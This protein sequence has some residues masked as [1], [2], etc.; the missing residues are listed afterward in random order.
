MTPIKTLLLTGANNHD[1]QRTAPFIQNLLNQSGKFEV[2]L[3]E[4]PSASLEANLDEYSLLFLDYNGPDWSPA[5][6]ANFLGAVRGGTGVVVLHAAN[7]SFESW[8][9]YAQL[10]GLVWRENTGHGEFHRFEVSIAE[11]NHPITRNLPNFSTED[12]LYHALMPV[13]GANL[14]VLAEAYSDPAQGGSGRNEPMLMAGHFGAGRVFHTALGHVW[15]D[16]YNG[17]YRGASLVAIEN[18]GFQTTLLRGCEWA[19]TGN[20]VEETP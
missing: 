15:P 20:V 4:A 8:D 1:W 6:Q 10:A 9:E 3:T 5:A 11:P 16:D 18:P 14:K 2:T 17:E 19:A 7:N 12:E 13:E